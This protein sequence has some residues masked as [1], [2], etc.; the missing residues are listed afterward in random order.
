MAQPRDTAE[1]ASPGRWCYPREAEAAPAASGMFHSD[2]A[3]RAAWS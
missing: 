1:P 3:E 2:A